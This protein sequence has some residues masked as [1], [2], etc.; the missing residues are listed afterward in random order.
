MVHFVEDDGGDDLAPVIPLFGSAS[1]GV[2]RPGH[3][4]DDEPF[5]GPDAD[6]CADVEAEIAETTLL[7]RLRTRQLSVKEARAV[8]SERDLDAASVD[9]VI[10]RFVDLRYLDDTAL[11]EQLVHVGLD[12]KGQGR[13]AIAQTLAQRGIPREVADEAI[14]SLPDDDAE[15]A[16]EFARTKVRQLD[17]VDDDTALR[18]LVGQLARRGY[19]GPV[20]MDA[21]RAALKE[22][23]SGGGVRFR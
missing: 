10:A 20:A 22:Q 1:R 5:D 4:H 2:R 15:R 7:R 17:R 23:R 18:R 9:H 6:A 12:R 21:A 8:V 16:L 13:K 14:A 11:A 3:E 19:P